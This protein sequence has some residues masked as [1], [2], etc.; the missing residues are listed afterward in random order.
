MMMHDPGLANHLV[1]LHNNGYGIA[2]PGR[3]ELVGVEVPDVR[4]DFEHDDPDGAASKFT[5]TTCDDYGL[6]FRFE[7][8]SLFLA[9][10]NPTDLARM[11]VSVDGQKIEKYIVG[12]FDGVKLPL[13]GI[14]LSNKSLTVIFVDRYLNKRETAFIYTGHSEVRSN[15]NKTMIYPNPAN[16]Q[17]NIVLRTGHSDE[18]SLQIF[19]I[20]G[21]AYFNETFHPA[22]AEETTIPVNIEFL[23]G[24]VYYLRISRNMELISNTAFIKY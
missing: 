21:R 15:D 14:T 19:D 24:G 3:I 23:K 1:Y 18:V 20:S 9:V 12:D 10:Q 7:E 16:D 6:D 13:D 8:D 11:Q 17:L 4:K 5:K 2:D 22:R